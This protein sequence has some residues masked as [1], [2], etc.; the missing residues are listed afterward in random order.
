[1]IRA[2]Q[3]RTSIRIP[4]LQMKSRVEKLNIEGLDDSQRLEFARAK[5]VLK[6][7]QNYADLL[8]PDLLPQAFYT[9]MQSKIQSWNQTIPHLNQV[10]DEILFYLASYG[11]VYIPKNQVSSVV[12]EMMKAYSDTIKQFLQE[13][14]FNKIK[15]DAKSIENYENKLLSA[16]DSI[17]SQIANS[18]AQ[19]QTWFNEIQKFRNNCFV[20]QDNN[21]LS[22]ETEIQNAK[23]TATSIV[24]DMEQKEKEFSQTKDKLDKFYIKIFGTLE[25]NQ[26]VGGLEQEI[27]EIYNQ[28]DEYDKQQKDK[29]K[30]WSDEIENLL[31]GATNASL[32]SSY[33]KSKESYT[34]AIYGWNIAFILSML[35]IV[36]IAVWGFVEV[37]D[38]L[39]EPLAILGAILVR[40]PFYIPLAWLAIFSTQRRNESKRLQEEYKH[41]ETLA[42]SFLGYKQ[43]IDEIQSDSS[44]DDMNLAKKLMENLVEMTNENPNKSLDKIKKEN[45]PM[46]DF[47]EK[48]SKSSDE[49]KNLFK[50]FISIFKKAQ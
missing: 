27:D 1:M 47:F 41:K 10:L 34:N 4:L 5:K 30:V 49:A 20:K 33:E 36:G 29:I 15:R 23:I 40:L 11:S 39:S 6:Y 37:A 28:L 18:Q 12:D 44:Q 32:A 19:I 3:F 16:D 9:Q 42:R 38:K 8:D 26:R 48:L 2:E 24:N 21:N 25:N 22:L 46:I 13:V 31:K 50:D 45:M 43:Q 14:D 17:Q 35:S 7:I